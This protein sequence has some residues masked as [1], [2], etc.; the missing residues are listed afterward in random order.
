M[1]KTYIFLFRHP[2]CKKVDWEFL[3]NQKFSEELSAKK[4]SKDCNKKCH[5][6]LLAF[7]F[8]MGYVVYF[9]YRVTFSSFQMSSTYS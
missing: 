3:S 7:R 8:I 5:K 1:R 2:V 9:Y 6:T 4:A